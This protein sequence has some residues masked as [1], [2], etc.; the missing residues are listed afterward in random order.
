M[1]NKKKKVGLF[2]T[3]NQG[4]GSLET[5]QTKVLSEK[6]TQK[7]S[8]KINGLFCILFLRTQETGHEK[9]TET[10]HEI[11]YTKVF[12]GDFEDSGI[13]RGGNEGNTCFLRSE[14]CSFDP[15]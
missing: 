5:D 9:K 8:L 13:S 14:I 11:G 1:S 15:K 3:K 12:F 10:G 6:V 4:F 2:L 7:R